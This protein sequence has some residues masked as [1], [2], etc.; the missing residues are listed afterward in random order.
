MVF[1]IVCK[2]FEEFVSVA[3][4]HFVAERKAV[5]GHHERDTHLL[6]VGAMIAR[7]TALAC[8]LA[9]AWPSK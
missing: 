9:A 4:E 8:G 3:G 7:V 2:V 6:A 1:T 5:K